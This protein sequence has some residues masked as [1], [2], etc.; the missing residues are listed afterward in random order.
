MDEKQIAVS[1]KQGLI[2]GHNYEQFLKE[3]TQRASTYPGL[4]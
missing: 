3:I 1:W 2:E 4:L